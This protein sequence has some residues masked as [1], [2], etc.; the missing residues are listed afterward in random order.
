MKTFDAVVVGGGVIGCSLARDLAGHGWKVAVIER[1]AKPGEES[2]WA[3]AGMLSPSA[4]AHEGSPLFEL[5][6][7][8]LKLYRAFAKELSLETGIDP[9]YRSEGTL[10]LFESEM[11]RQRILPAIEWQKSRGAAIEELSAKQVR[12]HEPRLNGRTAGFYIAD[13]HQIDNRLLVRAL[14]ESCRRS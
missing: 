9:Q 5:G 14:V 3:A 2:S 7:A 11:E 1:G 13:D 10:L 4:E 12:E 8:S 6:R